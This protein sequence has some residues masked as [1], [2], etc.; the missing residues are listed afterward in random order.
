MDTCLLPDACGSLGM[1]LSFI[2]VILLS[3][4]VTAVSHPGLSSLPYSW[5][6]TFLLAPSFSHPEDRHPAHS[7][8]MQTD[9]ANHH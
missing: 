6:M 8:K 9:T 2:C 5:D 3:H 4:T 1:E 7:A